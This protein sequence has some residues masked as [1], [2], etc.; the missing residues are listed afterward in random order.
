MGRGWGDSRFPREGIGEG[1]QGGC[2]GGNLVA[3]IV[4]MFVPLAA[5]TGWCA[6]VWP[7]E[8]GVYQWTK[9]ALGPFAGFMSAWNFGVWALLAVSNVG[10]LTAT[11]LSYGLGPRAAWMEENHTLITALNIGLF[12]LILL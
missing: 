2:G 10:I 12:T 6:K 7:L 9:Y 5:V 8:G 3:A 1:L 11:S 4:T